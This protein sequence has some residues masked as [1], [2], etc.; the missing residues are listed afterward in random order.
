MD[1]KLWS[2]LPTEIVDNIIYYVGFKVA[3]CLNNKYVINRYIKHY[4]KEHWE[5]I[6]LNGD[7]HLI[8]YLYKNKL[9]MERLFQFRSSFYAY[10][11]TYIFHAAVESGDLFKMHVIDKILPKSIL[12]VDTYNL[13]I[14]MNN[15]DMKNWIDKNRPVIFFNARIKKV[16]CERLSNNE[17]VCLPLDV[18]ETFKSITCRCKSC[19]GDGVGY[20]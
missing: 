4:I 9:N 14:N 11:H 2:R 19:G 7:G 13:A 16:K 6:F 15:M 3:Y 1:P 5:Y 10:H 17:S 8:W 12:D 18:Q 20:V